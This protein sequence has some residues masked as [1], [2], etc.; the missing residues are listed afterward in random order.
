LESRHEAI[1]SKV[2]EEALRWNY[3]I[4]P[5][6]QLS[7]QNLET[8]SI[9]GGD[10]TL[11]QRMF[12]VGLRLPFPEI[13]QDFM[14]FLM[15]APSQIISNAWRYLFASYILWKTVLRSEMNRAIFQHISKTKL[16]WHCG[17]DS[18]ASANLHTVEERIPR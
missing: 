13:A 1:V 17:I 3:Y 10:I 11:F 2:N 14:L 9:D 12:M 4:P 18:P 6:I 15:V 7:F 5:S 16:G 8:R